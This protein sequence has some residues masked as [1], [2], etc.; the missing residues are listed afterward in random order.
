[1]PRTLKLTMS[2]VAGTVHRF[3]AFVDGRRVIDADGTSPA[4]WTGPVGD[5]TVHI[6]T[7][8]FGV[9]TA[10]YTLS[11]DLPGTAQDQSLTLELTGGYHEADYNI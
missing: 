9:G 7:R 6:R 5:D 4:Q 10:K 8:V 11:I 3:Y 1:M 2:P